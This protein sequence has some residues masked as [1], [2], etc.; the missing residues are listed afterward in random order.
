M[1]T[2]LNE[3]VSSTGNSEV[4]APKK[5]HLSATIN[6]HAIITVAVFIVASVVTFL[7]ISPLIIR[8][9]FPQYNIIE[10]YT[11]VGVC[12]DEIPTHSTVFLPA[13]CASLAHS[14]TIGCIS[15][16]GFRY[17]APAL[18]TNDQKILCPTLISKTDTRGVQNIA[19]PVLPLEEVTLKIIITSLVMLGLVSLYGA[20]YVIWRRRLQK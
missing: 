5:R 6:R 7:F 1:T 13:T 20:G 10:N 18:S 9:L 8:T 15:T 11:T 2:P 19:L 17:A 14:S 12:T 3:P 4:V 16:L